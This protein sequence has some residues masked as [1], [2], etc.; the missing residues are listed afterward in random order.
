MMPVTPTNITA[1][2]CSGV[3]RCPIYGPQCEQALREQDCQRARDQQQEREPADGTGRQPSSRHR[4]RDAGNGRHQHREHERSDRHAQ[5]IEPERAD[6]LDA[7]CDCMREL[8]AGM[9]DPRAQADAER[10][11]AEDYPVP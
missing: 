5:C 2:N 1:E 7:A 3:G 10:Q 4:V 8:A 6:R 11:C 9:I